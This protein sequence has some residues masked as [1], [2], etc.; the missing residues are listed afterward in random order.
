MTA[1]RAAIVIVNYNGG[2]LLANAV[3]S[4]LE[5]DVRRGAEGAFPVVVVDNASHDGSPEQL[6]VFG[7]RIT[8]VRS[9]ENI[10]YAGGNNL[11]FARF[12]E[13]QAFALLNPDAVAEPGWL[14]ALLACAGRHPDWGV[15]ASHIGN[16]A[17]PGVLDNVGHRMALDGTVRGR[18]RGESDQGQYAGE[19]A[20]MIA[21]GCALLLRGDAVRAA[22]GFDD[23]FF[24]YCDDVE[25]CLRLNLLGYDT[26]YA[27]D[28]RVAHHFSAAA[29][30]AFNAFKAYHVERNRYW[31]IAKCFPWPAVPVALGASVARYVWASI[32][33]ARGRGPAARLAASTGFSA[34]ALTAWRAHRDA[35]LG[36]PRALRR[37]AAETPRRTLGTV[38]FLRRWRR[39]YLPMRVAVELE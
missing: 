17:V 25:L 36:L 8:L 11:A 35:L 24:C 28:A 32:A 5:Q 16:A 27:P 7:D 30:E 1:V 23:S 22:G 37:R 12:P 3:R 20:L 33:T 29:G 34:V 19:R 14:A 15:I 2:A 21:S 10:G 39:D 6:A 4:A 26:W 13:A 9:H 31:V 18:G 38:E